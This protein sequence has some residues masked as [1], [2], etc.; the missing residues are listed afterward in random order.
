[1][2]TAASL[3]LRAMTAALLAS[4]LLAGCASVTRTPYVQPEL[5]AEDAWEQ[6]PLGE[7]LAAAGPWWNEFGDQ[8]LSELVERVLAGN[9]DLAAAGIRLGQARLLSNLA[10]R[11]LFPSASGGLSSGGSVALDGGDWSDGAS[12][13]VNAGW[14]LDLFG[15]LDAERDA[16]AW[17][18]EATEQDL[19]ATRLSLIGTTALA[20]WQ[21]GYANEQIALGERSL[22]YVRR[23]LELVERQYAAGAVSRLSLRD[24]Q[25]SVA[26]QEATQT[27]LV[28]ARVEVL[29]A[30]AALL[31]QQ[32]YDGPDNLALPTR[33]LP[34][35]E[36]GLPAELL[37]RRPD[38]AAAELRLRGTLAY[39]DAAE[40]SYYPSLGLTG[41]LGTA[42]SALLSF[43]SNPVASLSAALSIPTLDPE[44]V[45]LGIG[46]ARADYD[47]AAENFRQAFYDALR[48]TAI[49]L[50]ARDQYIRQAV[51]LEESY[52]AALDAE[53]LYERQY[54]AGLIPLRDWLDAQERLRS[55]ESS[56][57]QNR[58]NLLAAQLNLYQ[59]LGGAP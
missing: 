23:A 58:Y 21:L 45:R 8:R 6:Q 20:W 48:D 34:L 9:G 22:D 14:E 50:S 54:R 40:A 46:I 35:V 27:Q 55:S 31:G 19:A 52:A 36:P 18:A 42:S 25:Q 53:A 15:R 13:S 38:L 33:D 57:L 28:Q 43:L 41:S 51:F 17:D 11:Q 12:A 44:R 30:L 37:A 26:S 29:Q 5:P 24:A 16:A 32:S 59:A 4:S 39:A 3:R 49:A 56:L 7:R 10:A 47:I 2:N 1:M